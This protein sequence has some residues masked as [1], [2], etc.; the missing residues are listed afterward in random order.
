MGAL[1]N[2]C[3]ISQIIGMASHTLEQQNCKSSMMF[4]QPKFVQCNVICSLWTLLGGLKALSFQSVFSIRGKETTATSAPTGYVLQCQHQ[5][6]FYKVRKRTAIDASSI[7]FLF[8]CC[9]NLCHAHTNTQ[10][11]L[12][13]CMFTLC[14]LGFEYS[15]K[16]HK[17]TI[18]AVQ[19]LH[20]FGS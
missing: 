18:R 19:H 16:I 12:Q 11:P 17:K 20:A 13:S 14:C 2:Y 15:S 8:C 3:S 4:I 1:R 7:C 6:N 9:V 5:F 10:E